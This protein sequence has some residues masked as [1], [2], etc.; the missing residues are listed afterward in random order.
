LSSRRWKEQ[1][2]SLRT[3]RAWRSRTKIHPLAGPVYVAG[4]EPGDTLVVEVHRLEHRGWGWNGV[5]PGFGLLVDDFGTPYIHHYA[6][7]GETCVFRDDIRIPFEP[8]CGVM[9]VA[10][11]EP[12]RFDTTPPRENAGNID[13]SSSPAGTATRPRGTGR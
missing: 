7:E 1:A 8:F 13:I 11:R 2:R 9:G 12:G 10:P 5:I 3:R 6:L 4:A